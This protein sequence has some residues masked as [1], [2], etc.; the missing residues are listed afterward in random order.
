[1]FQPE[2][3]GIDFDN[4]ATPFGQCQGT[5]VVVDKCSL[6][7]VMTYY[8]KSVIMYIMSETALMINANRSATKRL[9]RTKRQA[10]L[11]RI[12]ESSKKSLSFEQIAEKMRDDAWVSGRWPTYSAQTANNDFNTVMTLVEGDVRELAMP[13][14]ARGIELSDSAIRLLHGFAQDDD[15]SHK[16]RID[17]L[18]AMLKYLDQQN[19][20]FGNYAAK[21]M[22]IKKAE[23]TVD[24]DTF[25]ELGRRADRQLNDIDFIDGE[26]ANE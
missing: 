23:L 20:V 2:D 25:M 24:L 19:K 7:V 14:I 21:E 8:E 26:F 1:M 6:L 15:L 18:N 9:E 12:V 13:Y 3:W 22:N 17:S 5:V 11:M 10:I 16:I 4:S